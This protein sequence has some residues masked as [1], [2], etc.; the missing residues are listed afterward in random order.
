MTTLDRLDKLMDQF[1]SGS[2]SADD[3]ARELHDLLHAH[4]N[5]YYC[6]RIQ[7]AISAVEIYK[8]DRN[9]ESYG[10]GE[11]VKLMLLT[12]LTKAKSMANLLQNITTSPLAFSSHSRP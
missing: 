6:E 2:I 12:D 11:T 8:S 5:V 4:S 1:K 10:G 9:T 7:D 3:I